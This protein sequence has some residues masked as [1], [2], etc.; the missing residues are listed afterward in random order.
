[1]SHNHEFVDHLNQALDDAEVPQHH[2]ERISCLASL[3]KIRKAKAESLLDGSALPDP[4]LLERLAKELEVSPAWL[5]GSKEK[6]LL[7]RPLSSHY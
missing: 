4:K 6:R 5:R 1:M 3:V 7:K 2:E